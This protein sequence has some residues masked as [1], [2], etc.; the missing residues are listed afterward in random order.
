M[1]NWQKRCW[2][3]P[4]RFEYFLWSISLFFTKNKEFYRTFQTF[5]CLVCS[6]L[7]I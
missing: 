7:K 2:F 6:E 5:L 1:T 3:I 4:V